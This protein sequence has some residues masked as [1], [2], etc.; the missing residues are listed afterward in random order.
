MQ[1]ELIREDTTEGGRGNN[2]LRSTSHFSMV[3][4][5][6]ENTIRNSGD[7][8]LDCSHQ[9]HRI[10]S[11]S[12]IPQERVHVQISLP[13]IC[14]YIYIKKNIYIYNKHSC[15]QL[16]GQS[17]LMAGYWTLLDTHTHHRAVLSIA[18]TP[19]WLLL[20]PFAT[21]FGTE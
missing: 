3:I 21:A 17:L 6:E 18:S 1:E 11:V 9:L 15:V 19:R 20:L 4:T 2:T 5:G 14:I 16:S 7:T 13:Y 12:F 10:L 8:Q